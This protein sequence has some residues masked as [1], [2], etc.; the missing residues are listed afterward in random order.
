MNG[1][2]VYESGHVTHL[3][4]VILSST[5][6][7]FRL[8]TQQNHQS[9]TKRRVGQHTGLTRQPRCISPPPSSLPDK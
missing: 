9:G 5:S 3:G 4:T 2:L 8:N 7:P 6:S 1:R